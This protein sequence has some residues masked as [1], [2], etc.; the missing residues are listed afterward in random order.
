[1]TIYL[2]LYIVNLHIDQKVLKLLELC[3]SSTGQ[4]RKRG[5]SGKEKKS[6]FCGDSSNYLLCPRK[7]AF[8]IF[9]MS[10][11]LTTHVLTYF[12]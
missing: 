2:T 10:L 5:S 9:Y 1:M 3:E 11:H 6:S 12:T 4:F 7:K 8:Y